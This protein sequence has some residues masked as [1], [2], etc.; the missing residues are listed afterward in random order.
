M[1]EIQTCRRTAD[2][3]VL[4]IYGIASAPRKCYNVAMFRRAAGIFRKEFQQ[5]RDSIRLVYWLPLLYAIALAFGMYYGKPCPPELYLGVAIYGSLLVIWAKAASVY[6]M[7]HE[8]NTF[9]F[10]RSLPVSPL[11][12]ALGKIGFVIALSGLLLAV[13]LLCCAACWL[14]Q[15]EFPDE[16]ANVLLLILGPGIAEALVWGILWS[17]RCRNAAFA[18]LGSV[19]C[20][21]FIPVGLI[22]SVAASGNL[23][24]NALFSI[25]PFRLAVIVLVGILA[26]RSALRWFDFSVKEPRRIFP[27][28]GD[29]ARNFSIARYPLKVQ[30]PFLALIH[31]H[32]R[33]ASL[34]YPLG[35]LCFILFSLG[36]LLFSFLISTNLL[37]QYERIW[38]RTPCGSV[39]GFG[40]FIFWGNIFGHD[41]RNESYRFLGRIGVHEGKVWWSR[42]LPAAVLYFPVLLCW[43][44][45]L[46]TAM[47]RAEF[48][49]AA[50]TAFTVWLSLLALG[51]V[52]SISCEKQT[53]G[54][55]MTF[56]LG[57]GLF[58][59]GVLFA[60]S[61]GSSPLW[62]TVPIA[63]AFLVA[64]RLRAWYWLREIT[65]RRSRLIPLLPVFG[66]VLAI[67]MALPFVRIYSVPHISREQIDTY[68]AGTP[69]PYKDQLLQNY[70]EHREHARSVFSG[71]ILEE[72]DPEDWRYVSYFCLRF[73]PWEKARRERVLRLEIV[74]ALAESGSLLEKRALSLRDFWRHFS[75]SGGTWDRFWENTL[76]DLEDEVPAVGVA[77]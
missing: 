52:C 45:Y 17:T 54:I 20:T 50:Q 38:W 18:A 6:A 46:F 59:W 76:P 33:H 63:L 23:D 72:M 34:V 32:V 42:M 30:T 22:V 70:A 31:Q 7:E 75:G 43:L 3:L 4:T 53:Q 21:V 40:M 14:L 62:T 67:L 15:G 44:L 37:F 25:L 29:L 69:A 41:Q 12:V 58:V 2:G 57:Y 28:M 19:A 65:T 24:T 5:N 73:M 61:F 16:K 26:C 8:K 9:P 55:A 49:L 77:E 35:I 51:A 74:A 68:L 36:C 71:Q 47:P 66:A 64:S 1:T 56:V 60:H 27:V 39:L 10:L 11:S 48:P 13:N